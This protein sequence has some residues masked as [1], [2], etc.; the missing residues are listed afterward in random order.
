MTQTPATVSHPERHF[1]HATHRWKEKDINHRCI[2]SVSPF[3]LLPVVKIVTYLDLSVSFL[4]PSLPS[5]RHEAFSANH[6]T[7]RSI[8]RATG[9]KGEGHKGRTNEVVFDTGKERNAR[10]SKSTP[11][12]RSIGTLLDSLRVV[13]RDLLAI[14]SDTTERHGIEEGTHRREA[15]GVGVGSEKEDEMRMLNSR[16]R[17]LSIGT[18][19]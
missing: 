8:T 7:L 14:S 1:Y 4:P 13:E 2:P 19:D 9:T 17:N 3:S 6:Q 12:E 10:V 5:S 18:L 11:H 16:D 15:F